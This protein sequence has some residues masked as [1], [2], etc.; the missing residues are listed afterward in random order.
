MGKSEAM[1]EGHPSSDGNGQTDQW[2]TVSI[3][4]TL[5]SWGSDRAVLSLGMPRPYQCGATR[6]DRGL[7]FAAGM[8]KD[9]RVDKDARDNLY[10]MSAVLPCDSHSW[11][12]RR[13]GG[14][15]TVKVEFSSNPGCMK[16]CKTA[17]GI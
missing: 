4:A 1:A 9:Y 3:Y 11:E 17:R 5:C 7:R 6:L 12:K 13:W 2:A 16:C 8:M 10:G 15:P 14:C